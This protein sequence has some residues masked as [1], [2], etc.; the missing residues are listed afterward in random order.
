MSHYF[1]PPPGAPLQTSA[2]PLEIKVSGVRLQMQSGRG[3]FSKN[4]FDA[5]S[6]LL[7]Q[8][9]LNQD[10]ASQKI[11]DL[12]CGLGII[13]CAIAQQRP[14]AQIALCDINRHAALLAA[15]NARENHLPN[16]QVFCGDGLGAV[17]DVVFDAILCNPPIR[18]GNVVIQ[19]LFDDAAR[20]LQPQ[21]A[22]WIVV[23]TAQGAKSWERKLKTQWSNCEAVALHSGFRVFKVVA[24]KEAGA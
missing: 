2:R 12:G 22:L 6:R 5:G 15:R 7:L 14:H 17:R 10:T 11:C 23:R 13:G 4:E 18:A 9:F 24:Q 19:K 16:A 8:T 21:G 3:V 20:C 1:S